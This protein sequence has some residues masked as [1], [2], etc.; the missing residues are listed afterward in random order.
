MPPTRVAS[1]RVWHAQRHLSGVYMYA[2]VLVPRRR[3]QA[4]VSFFVESV[5]DG[6]VPVLLAR[7]LVLRLG[8]VV[9]L[10]WCH[11]RRVLLLHEVRGFRALDS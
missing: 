7:L 11:A 8:R 5:L 6:P 4:P 3:H 2:S 1:R 9:W 10:D